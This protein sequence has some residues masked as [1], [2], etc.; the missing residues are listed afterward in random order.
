MDLIT[1]AQERANEWL[2]SKWFWLPASLNW[3][4]YENDPSSGIYIAQPKDLFYCIP[5]AL[6][7]FCVRMLFER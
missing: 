5:T 7:I 4:D 6:A 1:E 2:F 3:K